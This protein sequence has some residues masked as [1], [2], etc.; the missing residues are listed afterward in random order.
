MPPTPTPSLPNSKLARPPE[1]STQGKPQEKV[2]T[3][4]DFDINF[5]LN[6]KM[7]LSMI[8]NQHSGWDEGYSVGKIRLRWESGKEFFSMV[9]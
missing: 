1:Q 8:L 9:L 4:N 3:A 2:T 7:R 5:I 6:W